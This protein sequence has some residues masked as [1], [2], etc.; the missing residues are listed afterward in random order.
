[1]FSHTTEVPLGDTHTRLVSTGAKGCRIISN[2][3]T[4]DAYYLITL[5]NCFAILYLS[6]L[7]RPIEVAAAKALLEVDLGESIAWDMK[8]RTQREA[9][10]PSRVKVLVKES[11]EQGDEVGASFKILNFGEIEAH[12]EQ[13][14]SN[15]YTQLIEKEIK[16]TFITVVPFGILTHK[17]SWH[18]APREGEAHLNGEH[19][20]LLVVR[21]SRTDSAAAVSIKATRLQFMDG[22][23]RLWVE[24]TRFASIIERLLGVSQQKQ[25]AFVIA[26]KTM[27]G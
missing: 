2:V 12:E 21:S 15:E 5:E 19:T 22:D 18:F 27:E 8:P 3:P 10:N 25:G 11:R 9:G 23:K 20:C 14:L 7:S 24:R 6:L 1:M 4:R 26:F 17:P 16:A 13:Q